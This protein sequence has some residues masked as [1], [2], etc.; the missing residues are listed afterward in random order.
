MREKSYGFMLHTF[1]VCATQAASTSQ[2]LYYSDATI[3]LKD[4]RVMIRLAGEIFKG[5]NKPK[6][7]IQGGKQFAVAAKEDGEVRLVR[8][9]DA[10]MENRSDDPERRINFRARHNCDEPKSKLTAGYWSC[11]AW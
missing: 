7:D 10:N 3:N 1:L 4:G 2:L 9:G 11:K 5:Y 8:F 6:R